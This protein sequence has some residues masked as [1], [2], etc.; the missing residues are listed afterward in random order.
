MQEL[1]LDKNEK[2]RDVLVQECR[3]LLDQAEQ[4][5]DMS[6]YQSSGDDALGGVTFLTARK[7]GMGSRSKKPEARRA[8][9]TREKII[10]LEGSR[11]HGFTFPPWSSPPRRSEFDLGVG[12]SLYLYVVS[13]FIQ[14]L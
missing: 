10:L 4:I 2:K 11:L 8:L 3:D 6:R 13:E 14:C 1:R 9:T 5:K 7:G 12:E